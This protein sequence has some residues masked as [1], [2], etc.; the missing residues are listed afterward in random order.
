ME[1]VEWRVLAASV[2]GSMHERLELPCQDAF[3]DATTP[4]GALIVAVADGAGS[5]RYAQQG[6]QCAVQAMVEFLRNLPSDPLTN[7]GLDEWRALATQAIES[8]KRALAEQ[9]AQHEATVSDFATTLIGVVATPHAVASVQI[10]DGAVVLEDAQGQLHL[11]THTRVGEYLNE[12]VFLTSEGALSHARFERWEGTAAHLAI[13]TD[14]LE[15]LALQLPDATPYPPFFQPL[16]RFVDSPEA[17]AAQL[18]AFL[19]SERVR[20]RT[21]DD[22]TLV[23]IGR[24]GETPC[25]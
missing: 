18:E 14:G 21:D 9:A 24:K 13:F 7:G 3:A 16:F 11:L 5:A 10:G 4:S 1:R 22:L 8:V 12:T 25:E 17:S 15:L 23:L 20:A 19:R 6:A 2:Q